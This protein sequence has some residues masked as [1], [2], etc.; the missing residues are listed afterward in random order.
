MKNTVYLD[1]AATSF[2][3]PE[4][5]YYE[6]YRCM[7]EYCGNPGRG[8]NKMAIRASETLY[9]ARTALKD[10]FCAPAEENV[11]FTYNATYALNIAVKCFLKRGSTVLISDIEHNAVYRPVISES[12]K[13]NIS[14]RIFGTY[15]GDENKIMADIE[16]KT[17]YNTSAIIC[18][19]ASNI[20]NLRLPIKRIGKFAKDRN[21]LFILDASQL[22]GHAAIDMES[23]NISILCGPFHKALYGPQ[24]GGFMIVGKGV[25]PLRTL[26][27]GGSGYDSKVPTM[28]KS[29]PEMFEA[30]TVSTP[31][32]AG[33]TCALRYLSNAGMDNII[34]YENNIS[35]MLRYVLMSYPQ[36]E[37]HGDM[38]D[39]GVFSVTSKALSVEELAEALDRQG[40]LIRAGMHCAPLAHKKLGTYEDGTV[41]FSIGIF[42][43]D[44]DIDALSVAL[45]KIFRNK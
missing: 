12:L 13:G 18:T 6:M 39:G 19:G 1:N 40:I 9:E 33:L 23:A 32:A 15:N 10:F 38:G 5:V 2:P 37:I 36:L 7:R 24:G 14:F 11:V 27:E 25:K 3:K 42:N 45:A 43:T 16:K 31:A 30:G 34:K 17:T 22:A 4:S 35:N 41:R 20:C 44:N 28:P 29:L 26:I 8:S 21:I